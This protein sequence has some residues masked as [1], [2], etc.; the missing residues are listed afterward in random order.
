MKGRIPIRWVIAVMLLLLSVLNYVDRQALSILATT[1]QKELHLSDSDYARVGQAFL[2]CYTISYFFAGRVVDRL[3]ARASE[4]IFVTWWSVANMLTALSS[5]FLS[6]VGFRSLLGIGEPG[7]Y[8]VSAKVVG[9][10]FPP[11]EKGVAAGMYMMG[12]TLGAAIAA[13]LVAWLALQ[14]GWRSA[15]IVTG[16]M[17][18]VVAPLWYYFYR[19][20][21]SHRWV[22]EKEKEL[23]TSHGLMETA[24]AK[25]PPLPFGT[26]ILWKPLWLV[27]G[28]RMLTDPIWYFYLV[29]FAK[30]LQE[31]RGMT[32]GEVGGT[33]WIVFVAADIGCL[34]AGFASGYFIRKGISPVNARLRVICATALVMGL[35]FVIPL[36]PGAG[37]AI[38]FASLFAGCVMMFMASCV[39]LPLDLF[40]SGSL[41][42]A[43][44]LI[45]MGGS[46]GGF[47][48]TGLIGAVLTKH[49][50]YDGLFTAMSFLHPLAALLLVLLL[51]RAVAHFRTTHP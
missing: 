5:G 42:S 49:H 1:I 14:Y 29:W 37:W 40:P 19:S 48:S 33:L 11:K 3:G 17:G 2:L 18:L 50:S 35:S 15:F 39:T 45:G 44:G 4:T 27:M 51:P 46:I 32:L 26:I 25:A 34:A 9:A 21:A 41:G 7:H 8:A 16:M 28:V 20:P 23:L 36:L 31:K 24:K 13:P 12:G 30:Y 38:A 6:M 43:Q 22:G 47:F 10:W